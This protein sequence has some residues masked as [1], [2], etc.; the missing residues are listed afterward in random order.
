MKKLEMTGGDSTKVIEA[1][2]LREMKGQEGII[3]QGCGGPASDWL[4]G[5]N[6]LLTE[7]GILQE[8]T[9][10]TEI[11]SFQ[12]DGLTNLLFPFDDTVKLKMSRLAT[13]RIATHGQF[14]GTWLSDYVDNRLG[15][16]RSQEPPAKEKPAMELVGLDGN[17]FSIMGRASGI[18]RQAGLGKQAEEMSR[19]VTTEAHSYD[20]A[21]RIVSEYVQT[22]LSVDPEPP[23]KSQKKRKPRTGQAR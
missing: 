3:F 18:L 16:F 20:E 13:W 23:Q 15:G 2:E 8:G 10:F 21:L 19:R 22:E 12:H 11:M 14:G 7:E 1:E 6:E 9:K 17:I 4:N 5:I